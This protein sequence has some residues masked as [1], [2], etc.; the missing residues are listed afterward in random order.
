MQD[1]LNEDGKFLSLQEFQDKFDLEINF[2][3][4]FQMIAAIPSELKRNA[5]KTERRIYFKYISYFIYPPKRRIY[6]S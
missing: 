6:F 4:Y 2:L 1:L 3:R 5:Y